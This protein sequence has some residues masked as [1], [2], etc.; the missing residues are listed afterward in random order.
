MTLSPILPWL[1]SRHN[2]AGPSQRPLAYH[3]RRRRGDVSDLFPL[4]LSCRF[5]LLDPGGAATDEAINLP[6]TPVSR[7]TRQICKSRAFS[8][9]RCISQGPG[10][11]L[12]SPRRRDLRTTNPRLDCGGTRR[13][14]RE[15]ENSPIFVICCLTLVVGLSQVKSARLFE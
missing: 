2:H 4:R 3:G 7:L 1:W 15:T 10:T 13:A 12:I 9:A 8:Y 11:F 5:T 6:L 14:R